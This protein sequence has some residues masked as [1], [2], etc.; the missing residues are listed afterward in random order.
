MKPFWP[1]LCLSILNLSACSNAPSYRPVP[2]PN[3]KIVRVLAMVPMHFSSGPDALMLRYQTDLKVSDTAALRKEVNEIWP[4]F[5][6]DV[7]KGNFRA[8]IVSAN[9][10]PSGIIIKEGHSYNFVFKKVEDGSWKCTND[11]N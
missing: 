1:L 5:Q 2:L 9:E 3:G 11:E 6:T 4:S 7:E 10:I 8:A